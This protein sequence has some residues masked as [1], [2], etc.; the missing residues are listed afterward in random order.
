METSKDHEQV[1]FRLRR[2]YREHILILKTGILGICCNS[3]ARPASSPTAH[4]SSLHAS[5][6]AAAAGGVPSCQHD[7]FSPRCSKWPSVTAA[8][9]VPMLLRQLHCNFLFG[10]WTLARTAYRLIPGQ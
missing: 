2:S 8:C 6:T 7:A 4:V 9:P 3:P 5:R 10:T 1:A